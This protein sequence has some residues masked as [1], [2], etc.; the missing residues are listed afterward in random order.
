MALERRTMRHI[1]AR[2]LPF[3]FLLYVVN[4]LDRTNVS[5][6]ALQMNDD[7]RFSPAVFGFGSGIFFLGYALFEVPSNLVLARVGA[8]RWISRIMITWGLL[9]A[10][11]MWVRTPGQFYTVRF[12]LGVAEAGFFPGVIY[13]LRD[14]FPE[15][16]RA[17]AVARFTIAIPLAQVV[18]GAIG[19]NLLGL[20]GIARLSGW[21]W[22]FL[23]EGLPAVVLGI[24]VLFY[25]PDRPGAAR[26]LSEPEQGWLAERLDREVPK[27]QPI[28]HRHAL[29]SLGNPLT[30]VLALGYFT[31]FAVGMAYTTWAPL[32]IKDAFGLH[33]V[34]TGFIT[35]AIALVAALFYLLAAARSDRSGDRCGYAAVALL[36][37]CAGCIG[38]ALFSDP[39]WRVIS[40]AVIPISGGI[41]LPS[42]WCL[43]SRLFGAGTLA[44]AIAAISS[45]G[46]TGG[47]FGPSLIGAVKH[48]TGGD[49]WAFL[50]LA[51]VGLVGAAMFG[52]LRRM[53]A[54]R[55]QAMPLAAVP[56]Q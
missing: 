36:I 8:R 6:A 54:F 18:S 21:Q 15:D 44:A 24:M 35:A 42:F 45:L 10:T 29:S 5:I 23:L 17:R 53:N 51:C 16:H 3:L 40:L 14:W 33:D 7:L 38:G 50:M 39:V 13:Y 26:W 37:A 12:L 52:A 34:M 48:A 30:W 28:G 1:S 22:L 4:Y 43:P 20:N 49:T 19:G 41:F 27:G 56:L 11:M 9:A 55:P 47:F 31:Y 46:S 32:I 25:L 2:L